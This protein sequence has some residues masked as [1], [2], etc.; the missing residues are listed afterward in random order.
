VQFGTNLQKDF[1]E[2]LVHMPTPEEP[3]TSSKKMARR[4]PAADL[5]SSAEAASI[6]AALATPRALG[7]GTFSRPAHSTP[8]SSARVA[9]SVAN[10]PFPVQMAYCKVAL[11]E[12]MSPKN[13]QYNYPFLE[14][15]DPI[16]LN[17]PDYSTVIKKPMDFNTIKSNIDRGLYKSPEEFSTDVRLVFT[18]C[19]RYNPAE[20]PFVAMAKKLQEMFEMKMARIPDE[21]EA[22][23]AGPSIIDSTDA[24]VSVNSVAPAEESALAQ[25]TAQTTLP[26]PVARSHSSTSKRPKQHASLASDAPATPSPAKKKKKQASQLRLNLVADS[27]VSAAAAAVAPTVMPALLSPA[28]SVSRDSL[29]STPIPAMS[30]TDA[31]LIA[32]L[33]GDIS[34][35]N[36]K[37]RSVQTLQER[38]R[39]LLRNC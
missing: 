14:P 36:A 18:N 10:Q 33:D 29:S 13:K 7:G 24:V 15:V 39:C 22:S 16:K 35:L 1:S 20:H 27:S 6:A 34:A 11:Q 37:I 23:T 38:V 3:V 9:A 28:A 30:S 12:L 19:Y 31:A 26:P 21:P 5:P 4:E 8:N 2:L 17:I 25:T 32:K